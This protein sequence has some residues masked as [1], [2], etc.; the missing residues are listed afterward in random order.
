VAEEQP[1]LSER[2]RALQQRFQETESKVAL[3]QD[4]VAS[5]EQRRRGRDRSQIARLIVYLFTASFLIVLVTVPLLALVP[6]LEP[7]WAV[8]TEKL[9]T[10]ISSV[11]LPV[12]T[13]VI[14]FYFGTE[15]GAQGDTDRR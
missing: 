11:L 1:E 8:L 5:E 4:T 7:L 6:R 3:Q 10:L 2:V 14:G 9:V 15:Q 13:L 12:V